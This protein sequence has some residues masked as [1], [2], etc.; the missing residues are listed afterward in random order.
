MAGATE[1]PTVHVGEDITSKGRLAF[2]IAYVH[3]D[4][5]GSATAFH[6][7]SIVAIEGRHP[8]GTHSFHHGASDRIRVRRGLNKNQP[9]SSAARGVWCALQAFSPAIYLQYRLMV[10]CCVAGLGCEEIPIV[11]ISACPTHHIDR[12]SPAKYLAHTQRHGTSFEVWIG[13]IHKVPIALAPEVFK[14]PSCFC[15]AWHLVAAA[16]FEQEHADVGI[17]GQ[18]ARNY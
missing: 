8:D 3:I 10:L 1:E 6:H 2:S 11:L 9:T 4:D 15:N 5:G 12:R 18:A 14:P 13:L 17:F 7:S 16:C